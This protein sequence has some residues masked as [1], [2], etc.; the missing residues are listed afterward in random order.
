MG[1]DL[2]HCDCAQQLLKMNL[3]F[4]KIELFIYWKLTGYFFDAETRAS[5]ARASMDLDQPDFMTVT[6]I[7]SLME[8]YLLH[9]Y[10]WPWKTMDT[11]TIQN[12][13]L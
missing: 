11:N 10:S 12:L 4:I 13:I 5:M 7:F 8:Q 6:I 3:L 2:K 1:R 9:E